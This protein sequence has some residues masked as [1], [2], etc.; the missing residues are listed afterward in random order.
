M[1]YW[2]GTEFPQSQ[3]MQL[4]FWP[5]ELQIDNPPD[6]EFPLSRT[7]LV[8]RKFSDPHCLAEQS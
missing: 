2:A 5:C 8:A 1:L 7:D 3:S 4:A 6:H